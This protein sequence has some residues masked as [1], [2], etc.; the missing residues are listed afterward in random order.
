MAL[1]HMLVTPLNSFPWV[2]SGLLEGWVSYKRL[3]DYL[4]TKNLNWYKYYKLKR[5]LSSNDNILIN[6][7]NASFKWNLNK[8]KDEKMNQEQIFNSDS[9]HLLPAASSSEITDNEETGELTLNSISFTIEKSK[10]IGVIGKVGTGKTSLLNAI[11]GEI[12]KF[13][14]NS[15]GVLEI[16]AEMLADGIAYVAQ[17]CWVQASTIRDNI[18]FGEH[19]EEEKYK[20]VL[21]ACALDDDLQVLS[22][23][24]QTKIGE[25]GITLSGGQKARLCLARACYQNKSLYLLDDPFSAVDTNVAKHIYD[26]CINGLLANKTRILS[27]HHLKFLLNADSILVIDKN[28]VVKQGPSN[29]IL[30]EYMNDNTIMNLAVETDEEEA[31]SDIKRLEGNKNVKIK[32]EDNI[33]LKENDEEEKEEGFIDSRVYK[34]YCQSIGIALTMFVLLLMVLTQGNS[35]IFII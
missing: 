10:F 35:N 34:Y 27:T 13:D 20:R 29:E 21:F 5:N 32:D 18:L 14:E 8:N 7:K 15:Q 22:N 11:L 24:D 4:N 9:E 23:G 33:N 16:D 30:P 3:R 31:A 19:Y 12:S 26:H 17:D 1:F 2:I 25:N 6:V 28:T